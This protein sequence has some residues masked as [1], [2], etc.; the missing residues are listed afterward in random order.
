VAEVFPPAVAVFRSDVG[1]FVEG[2]AKANGVTKEWQV[3]T[4]KAGIAAQKAGI[5]AEAA[6]NRAAVATRRAAEAAS[7]MAKA[8]NDA[9]A[10]A[11]RLAKG[12]I[13]ES[14]AA[15]AAAAASRRQATALEAQRTALV[16]TQR[17]AVAQADAQKAAAGVQTAA[18]AKSSAA[19]ASVGAAANKTGKIATVALAGIGIASIKLAGDFQ[20][21]TNVLVTAAGELP[22]NLGTIRTGILDIASATGTAWQKVTESVYDAEKAGFR[23]ADALKV[24]NAA[25]EAAR[26]E[27]AD[28]TTVTSGLTRAL[29]AYNLT[30]NDAVRVT[31]ALK[32]GAGEAH[33]TFQDYASGLGSFLSRAAAAKISLPD[34]LGVYSSLTQQLGAQQAGQNIGSTIGNLSN[35]KGPQIQEFGQLGIDV[36]DFEKRLGDGA[37][38]RGLVGSLNLLSD[39]VLKKMGPSGTLLLNTFNQSQLAAK[40]AGIEL[41]NLPPAAQKVAKAYADGSIT[42][43]EYRQGLKALP[44]N[45]AA[46]AQ[47]FVVTENKA[48]GFQ[49]VIRA[50]GPQ[51]QTYLAALRL[52]VGGQEGLSTALAATGQNADKTNDRVKRIADSFNTGGK[53]VQGWAITQ[54]NFNVQFD[55]FKQQAERVGIQLGNDLIPKVEGLFKALSKHP[56]VLKDIVTGLEVMAGAWVAIKIGN[57]V[58]GL[59]TLAARLLGVSTAARAAAASTTALAT[60][61]TRAGTAGLAGGAGLA[62]GSA[63]P[64]ASAA[65]GV[66]TAGR[67]LLP[68]AGGGVGRALASG[69]EK[70]ALGRIAIPVALTVVA[71]NAA[72]AVPGIIKDLQH[73][74]IGDALSK[75]LGTDLAKGLTFGLNKSLGDLAH[76]HFGKALGDVPGVKLAQKGLSALGIGGGK[77]LTAES[78]GANFSGTK[79]GLVFVRGS[80][81]EAATAFKQAQDHAKSFFGS[82]HDVA[83]IQTFQNSLGNATNLLQSN[84]RELDLNTVGSQSNRN[85]LTKLIVQAQEAAQAYANTTGKQSDYTAALRLAIPQIEAAAIKTGLHKSQVDALIN[86]LDGIPPEKSTNVGL[87]G[88]LDALNQV[89]T[90]LQSLAQI[91]PVIRVPIETFIANPTPAN[92]LAG[93][94]FGVDTS[95]VKNRAAGGLLR[96]PGSGT[97]DSILARVSNGEYV[98]RAAAVKQYGVGFFDALNAKRYA[99]GGVVTPEEKALKYIASHKK[100]AAYFGALDARQAALSNSGASGLLQDL[101]ILGNYT[102]AQNAILGY[103]R[104]NFSKAT[105][106]NVPGLQLAAE[107]AAA[108]AHAV[109]AYFNLHKAALLSQAHS[110]SATQ[111]KA[112]GSLYNELAQFAHLTSSDAAQEASLLTALR[113]RYAGPEAGSLRF[114]KPSR[115]LS[116]LS[117]AGA[118]TTSGGGFHVTVVSVL[119]GKEIARNTSKHQLATETRNLSNGATRLRNA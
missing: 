44:A 26:E 66:G 71:V 13:S 11:S 100:V 41:A 31:N 95:G 16:A 64:A 109:G 117:L 3:Q 40:D 58:V 111:R 36:V 9:A 59:S 89:N 80:L 106:A 86:S 33:A 53:D 63:L 67:F 32:T 76:G 74:H 62:A 85:G 73:G 103:N 114:G 19:W 61:E 29:S 82:I 14:E 88:Y 112:A 69:L 1:P 96:G 6:A 57:L 92:Q 15:D 39:T 84:T 34:A 51:A 52:L 54:K 5:Q 45:Q 94:A 118:P 7:L 77:P 50:G 107:N 102:H 65:A 55:Q 22:K 81:D 104:A 30:G 75:E 93:S 79:D 68:A 97:S 90:F 99:S 27:G 38:G 87:T 105:A 23:G 98:I 18:A 42:L 113:R 78:V 4:E 25:S 119:D 24:A 10:A 12:E 60:A 17:A 56:A 49:S 2:L 20:Q 115:D 21:Q 28:L 110:G 83:A 43:N 47:Q 48:K 8:Q 70:S 91:P 72:K 101:S 46:L 116:Y 37:G 35:V 108:V